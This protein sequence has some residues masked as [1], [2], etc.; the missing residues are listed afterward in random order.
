[1]AE[2]R[3]FPRPPAGFI[4]LILSRS[5][6]L[7]VD[8][9]TEALSSKKV[10]AKYYRFATHPSRWFRRATTLLGEGD[11]SVREMGAVLLQDGLYLNAAQRKGGVPCGTALRACGTCPLCRGRF[12]RFPLVARRN[13]NHQLRKLVR[14]ARAFGRLTQAISAAR[15]GAALIFP[16]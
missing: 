14:I 4:R 1:M 13:I 5:A 3:A 11:T 9:L 2:T 12:F 10:I 7:V 15:C 6:Q 8:K 16:A